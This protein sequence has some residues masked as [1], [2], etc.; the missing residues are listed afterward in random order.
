MDALL[1][2]GSSEQPSLQQI[3]KRAGV[4]V[5][6][7]Y[8]YFPIANALWGALVRRLTQVNFDALKAR[9]ESRRSAA[10]EA[11]LKLVKG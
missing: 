1:E 11:F 3:A 2:R 9:L 6:S 4:G 8:D 5:G 7:V 10:R